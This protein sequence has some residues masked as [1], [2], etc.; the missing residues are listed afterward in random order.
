V[1]LTLVQ[2]LTVAITATVQQFLRTR[3]FASAMA[4]GPELPVTKRVTGVA[5]VPFLIIATRIFLAK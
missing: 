3:L 4:V 5:L 1:M 2:T